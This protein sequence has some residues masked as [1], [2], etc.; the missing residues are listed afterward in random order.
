MF[1]SGRLDEAGLVAPPMTDVEI[2]ALIAG[3]PEPP[4][5]AE[6][7]ASRRIRVAEVLAA[8]ES[9]PVDAGLA[10]QLP[11]PDAATSHPAQQARLM[12]GW[13]R[14]ANHAHAHRGQAVAAVAADT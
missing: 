9:A 6:V 8:G 1:D 13:Q 4:N 5:A 2:D 3:D 7:E 11:D 10:G 14:V 12:V